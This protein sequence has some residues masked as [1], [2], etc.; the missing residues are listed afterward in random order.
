V[1]EAFEGLGRTARHRHRREELEGHDLAWDDLLSADEN[2][3]TLPLRRDNN[4]LFLGDDRSPEAIPDSYHAA[5]VRDGCSFHQDATP[6]TSSLAHEHR[7]MMGPGSSREPL[8]PRVDGPYAGA[9][10]ERAFAKFVRSAGLDLGVV[11]RWYGRARRGPGV[12]DDKTVRLFS[13]R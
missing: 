4:V 5:Q 12:K 11:P 10:T 2:K 6:R 13:R 8:E 9:P 3:A 1:R 7:L